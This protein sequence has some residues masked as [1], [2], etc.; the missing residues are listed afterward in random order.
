MKNKYPRGYMPKIE[1]YTYKINEAIKDMDS[2]MIKFYTNKL[3]YFVGRQQKL[4]LFG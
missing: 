1:Y 2:D 3:V 4:E